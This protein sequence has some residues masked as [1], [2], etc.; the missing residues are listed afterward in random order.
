MYV[1]DFQEVHDR[2]FAQILPKIKITSKKEAVYH[3]I[4]EYPSCAF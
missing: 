1:L 3:Q 2:N 4:T